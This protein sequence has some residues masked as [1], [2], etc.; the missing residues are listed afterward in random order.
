MTQSLLIYGKECTVPPVPGEAALHI[1]N[2][3]FTYPGALRPAL[4]NV[5]LHIVPGERV[6][7]IGPNGAGKS[8]L[9]KVIAGLESVQSGTVMIYGNLVGAC[10]HRV[11]YVPQRGDVDWAFPVTV[12]EV[13]MMG[14]YVHLGWLKRPHAADHEAVEQAL[15]V[16]ELTALSGQQIGELSGG[17]QQRV[18][19]ARTLAQEADLLLLDE[20]MNNLDVPSQETI[21]HT[22][23][24]LAEAGRTMIVST[25][26]LGIL[27]THFSRAVFLDNHVVVDGAVS[28]VLTADTLARAYGVRLC[29]DQDVA[30]VRVVD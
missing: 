25:H 29:T 28:E 15:E 12:R 21:F 16:M 14:R 13:V 20:P 10:H 5:S 2:L 24:R 27:P 9:I 4:E 1:A 18:M 26:D 7:L 22:L 11:G 17:Q 3:T 6:A 30:D 23:E 19:I 8:T